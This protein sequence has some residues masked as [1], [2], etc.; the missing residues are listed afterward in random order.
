MKEG[1]IRP[2]L[3]PRQRLGRPRLSVAAMK[4]GRIR[5]SLRHRHQRRRLR[6]HAA[7]KEGRIRPSLLFQQ[8]ALP[9]LLV[10]AMKEGRIR[11]SLAVGII[12]RNA[13]RGGRNEG[14]SNSTLVALVPSQLHRRLICRNEGG[15]NSTLVGTPNRASPQRCWAAMK[16]GRIRP[17]LPH[18]WPQSLV[19][20]ARRNEGG[21]NSTL[22]A[23]KTEP[24]AVLGNIGRNEGGSNSTL[25]VDNSWE[26]SL[27]LECRNEGGSNSTL[28]GFH[29]PING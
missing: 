24:G 11:P 6:P 27:P 7:M 10:A 17:S 18:I 16:E 4:E 12:N 26:D 3:R 21:S 20:S 13:R 29:S 5:P 14:G 1:R 23:G 15:S 2:S 28:V 19:E 8:V 25:V 22:V 9:F